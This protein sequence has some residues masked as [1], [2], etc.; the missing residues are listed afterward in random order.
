M[1]DF[2]KTSGKFGLMLLLQ[3]GQKG[4]AF[5]NKMLS[6]LKYILTAYTILGEIHRRDSTF[7]CCMKTF[8]N[9]HSIPYVQHIMCCRFLNLFKSK[10]TGC[11]CIAHQR[12]QCSQNQT[13]HIRLEPRM[14][15]D[16]QGQ[17]G[18]MPKAGIQGDMQSKNG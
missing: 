8:Y 12:I 11:Y 9:R 1:S 3:M 10:A 7:N 4:D 2:S 13:L 16:P 6:A 5:L 17:Y 18:L 15:P 14:K